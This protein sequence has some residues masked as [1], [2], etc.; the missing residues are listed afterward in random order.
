MKLPL[1][2]TLFF[3]LTF[4]QLAKAQF[5]TVH[6]MDDQTRFLDKETGKPLTYKDFQRL[7][8]EFPNQYLPIAV[9]DKYGNT[10]YYLVRKK[11]KVELE[12]GQVDMFGELEKP[13]VGKPVQPFVMQGADGKTYDSEQLRG[14]YVMLSFWLKFKKPFF[15]PGNTKDLVALLSSV[16]AKGI[17]V[18][19]LGVSYSSAEECR[20][21]MEE[22]D[23]GFVP[24]PD[25]R[26]FT[27]RYASL[28]T[29]SFLLI[30]P[31]GKVLA[32]S[33]IDSPLKLEKYF[34][35]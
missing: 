4:V 19:S 17:P 24:I 28:N 21:A 20:A 1:I 25:S 23:L 2:F 35:K 3:T 7:N 12:T 33:E 9:Y 13:I 32:T 34:K 26:G 18:V 31:D 8:R 16:K 5:E 29:P 30:D 22:F 15:G 6:R 14:S 27:I 10:D 11:L